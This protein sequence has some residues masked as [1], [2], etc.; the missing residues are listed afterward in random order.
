MIYEN[1]RRSH[2]YKSDTSYVRECKSKVIRNLRNGV[3]GC[4]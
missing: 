4:G 2:G 1:M 3:L